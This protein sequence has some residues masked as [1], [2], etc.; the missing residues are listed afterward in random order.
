MFRSCPAIYS[1]KKAS[2]WAVI[3][4]FSNI[5]FTESSGDN[6]NSLSNVITLEI[7]VHEF[8]GQL[9]VWFEPVP[10]RCAFPCDMGRN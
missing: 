8:F 2:I 10:V 6:I 4:S 9:R 1:Y 7:G 5:K 3:D